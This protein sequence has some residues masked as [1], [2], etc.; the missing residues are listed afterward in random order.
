M[1]RVTINGTVAATTSLDSVILVELREG[2]KVLAS[3]YY[4]PA[5]N[6]NTEA[7]TNFPRL[8]SLTA[9]LTAGV[10]TLNVHAE[11][12]N[13]GS[14]DSVSFTTNI[15]SQTP[16]M[17][18]TFVSQSV[19]ARNGMEI[20]K[21]YPVS[22]TF[23]NTGNVTWQAGGAHPFRLGSQSPQDNSNFS[24]GRVGLPYNIAPGQQYTFD[25]T[26]IPA[27]TLTTNPIFQWQMLSEGERW[28]GDFSLAQPITLIIP[29]PVA[30]FTSPTSNPTVPAGTILTF[31]GTATPGAGASIAK[32]ELLLNDVV[33][34]TGTT[35]VSA[36][37]AL[38]LG[39]H[40]LEL[41]ATDTRGLTGSDYRG[42]L[43]N[44]L[45]PNVRITAP[46]DGATFNLN[47]GSTVSVPITAVATPTAGT[48][49]SSFRLYVDGT[50]RQ[51]VTTGN[52][53]TSVALA[54][55]AHT[56][57]VE[58][59]DILG[60]ISA[61]SSIGVNV[62]ASV[63]TATLTS[64]TSNS[65]LVAQA[66][67]TAN[68]TVNGTAAATGGATITAFDLLDNGTVI[69]SAG[70]TTNF[71]SA[72]NLAVG[73]HVLSLRATSSAGRQGSSGSVT[74]TV[75]A[76]GT[77][78][79]AV[80]LSAAPGNVRVS[81]SQ[82]AAITFTASSTAASGTT[83]RTLELFKGTDAAGSMGTTPVATTTA[84]SATASWAPIINLPAGVHQFKLRSTSSNGLSAESRPVFVNV[85]NSALLGSTTGVRT[86]AG[87]NPELFG[88]TCQPGNAAA[89]TYKVLLDAPTIAAGAITLTSGTAD[90]ASEPDNAAIGNTCSTPGSPHHF[91]VNLSPYIA[92]YA[93]RPLYVAVQ[94]QNQSLGTTLPCADNSCTMPGTMRVALTTPQN[95][96]QIRYPNP[97]FVRMLLSNY[98]GAIDEVAFN[99]NG[100][101]VAAQADG[102]AG[103]YSASVAGLSASTTPYLVYAK[104]RQGN[105]TLLSMPR[106][107]TVVAGVVVALNSPTAGA[108]LTVGTAQGLSASAPDLASSLKFFANGA[109]V[110]TGVK[111]NG[112]WSSSWTPTAAGAF[113]LTAV[114]YDGAGAQVGQSA[115]VN[116]N[117]LIGNGSDATPLPVNVAT[118]HLD[119]AD[120]GTL[121]GELNVGADGA[122]SYRV[123]IEVPPGTAGMQPKLSLSYSSNGPN[124]LVGLGWSLGGLSTLHRCAKTI[125]QDGVV[126]RISVTTSDRLCLNGMRL[127]RSSGAN[128]AADAGAQDAAYWGSAGTQ[129][130][131]EIE[132]FARITSLSKGF[133]VEFKD[134]RIQYFGHD[135]DTG[136]TSSAI[137]AQGRSNESLLWALA[138]TEDRSGNTMTVTY[139]TDMATGEYVPMQIRYGAN[140]SA[141]QQADLAV[142]FSYETRPDAQ[143]QYMGGSRNDL[144][145]RLTNVQTF[146][147]TA[148]DGSAGTRVRNYIVRYTASKNSNRSLVDSIQACAA[149]DNACLPRTSFSWGSG[150]LKLTLKKEWTEYVNG[151]DDAFPLKVV[152]GDFAGDGTTIHLYP[153][154]GAP[155]CP[156]CVGTKI[157]P[158]T[159]Q[160]NGSGYFASVALPSGHKFSEVIAGDLDGD[161]RADMVFIDVTSRNWAY[162][163]AQPGGA[164]GTLNFSECQMGPEPLPARRI[165]QG[166]PDDLPNL[167][168]L[169]NDGKDQ[170]LAFDSANRVKVCTY[171][172]SSMSCALQS[173]SVPA[174]TPVFDVVPIDLSKQGMTDFYS[175]WFQENLNR[176]GVTLCNFYNN[177]LVCKTIATSGGRYV[178]T[179][180]ADLNG[181]GLTDFV[182]TNGFGR[183]VNDRR[184]STICLSKET[185]VDCNSVDGSNMP[186]GQDYLIPG[187]GDFTGNGLS[188]SAGT[189]TSSKGGVVRT[190]CHVADGTS[191]CIP[192]DTSAVPDLTAKY[193]HPPEDSAST[194]FIDSSGIP[195][196][197][198]C[199]IPHSETNRPAQGCV[200]YSAAL[201]ANEDRLIALVNGVGQREEVEY[202]RGDDATVYSR[203]ATVDGSER[204]PVYP[205]LANNPG[206]LVR[207]LRRDNGQGNWLSSSYRYAGAM[208]DALGRGSL[209]FAQVSVT[210]PNAVTT[211]TTFAQAFP[212][213]GMETRLVRSTASCVLEQTSNV[214]AQQA[215]S[216]AGGGHNF[217]VSV[218]RSDATRRDL[219]CS[220]LGT[221]QT[222][223]QYT[224]GW[225]NLNV[226]TV[227]TQNGTETFVTKTASV[228]DTGGGANYLSGLPTSVAVTKTNA[229]N[230]SL[231]RT[232]AYTNNTTSGLRET[233]TIEP[234][235]TAYKLL[236][237]YDRSLNTFGLVNKEVQSW[238]D[239]ACADAGWPSSLDGPCSAAKSRVLTDTTYDRKGRFPVT[240]KNALGHAETRSYDP[241]TGGMTQRLDANGLATGWLLDGFGR[242]T[243]ERAPDG[244]ETRHYL[245]AC[246]GSCPGGATVAQVTERF[247]GNA[248]IATPQVAYVDSA[249]H[250]VR[251][252]DWGFDGRKIVTDQRY[253]SLGRLWET[254]WPRFD[255]ATSYLASRHGYDQLNRI[256]SVTSVDEGGTQRTARTTYAGGKLVQTNAK[257]QVRTEWRDAIGQLRQVDDSNSPI[258]STLFEYDPFGNLSKTTDP[259]KNV[260][261]VTYDLLGRKT[262]LR[263]PDLGWTHYDVNPLGLPW[264][265][266]SPN[267]RGASK[268]YTAYDLLGRMTGRYEPDLESHWVYDS[269]A[270]G[271]GQLARASTRTA[272][273]Q[274]DYSR[275]HTYDSVGRP[276]LTRTVLSDGTYVNQTDYDAWGRPI[277]NT[278]QRNAGPAKVF[279]TR[280]NAFGYLARIERGNLALWQ[281]TA[282]DAARR[283]TTLALGN[284]LAQTRRFYPQTG[285]LQ[286]ASLAT[287]TN[288]ARL[289]EGYTYDPLGNVL[290][291]TQFWDA[292]GFI[293]SFTYDRLNRLATS[294][295]QGEASQAF[296]YDATGN[297]VSKT[298]TGNYTYST[299]GAN[300]V[301]PHAVQ[302]VSSLSGTFQYDANGNLR[303]GGG[304]TVTWTSFDMPLT[305]V[306]GSASATLV[307]GPEHQRVRQDRNDGTRIVYAGAQEVE[308]KNG[309]DTVKTYWPNGI[310][311][312]IDRGT[313]ATEMNWIHADRL[314]SVVALTNESGV[315]REKL[316]YDVWGKRRSASDNVSTP[317]SLDGQTDNRG[318]TGHEMLDQLDLVHMNGRVY[319]P[320]L[321]NFLSGDPIIQDHENGQ[322][323]NRYSYVFNNPTNLTDPTGFLAFDGQ[324]VCNMGRDCSVTSF[325]EASSRTREPDSVEGREGLTGNAS[326][327]PGLGQSNSANTGT[328]AGCRTNV[329]C[330][331]NGN[332]YDQ[333]D[334]LYHRYT[335]NSGICNDGTPGCTVEN[336]AMSVKKNAAPGSDGVTPLKD[337][338][339]TAIVFMGIGGGHVTHIVDDKNKRVLNITD[340]DHVFYNGLVIRSVVKDAGTVYVSSFGEGVNKPNLGWLPDALSKIG[341]IITAYPGFKLL[342][343]KIQRDILNQSP[344]GQQI[345]QQQQIRRLERGYHGM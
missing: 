305:I 251:K 36:T 23:K 299:Q 238:L 223:N 284:G 193:G 255:V 166:N 31:A 41:R 239:P 167:V 64:P 209:G 6:P 30:R 148:A 111:A 140:T 18:A 85:T 315:I 336:V 184:G 108:V 250:V 290:E 54:A 187:A 88:W 122:A 199:T 116:V 221:V 331:G 110:A 92:Q 217:F 137:P 9:N 196:F 26:V 141:N 215:F 163:L 16:I 275:T 243:S 79:T 131:T 244:N 47:S 155:Q 311:V 83:I 247:N 253:D 220:A 342:D 40:Q 37:R 337:G 218:G 318:F 211:E 181:D 90:V 10:H 309:V 276:S 321:G 183:G 332:G 62:T 302:T 8:F 320:Q 270:F 135:P 46:A 212:F 237:R 313:A 252:L 3:A 89:L 117:V 186:I 175:V 236:T 246:A 39:I 343:G 277:R 230:V 266:T 257:L 208:R 73:T 177:A 129:Y 146:I 292:G 48:V 72:V 147:N 338:D 229:A 109:L 136:D 101:W 127:F 7:P 234:S 33:I 219:D 197:K 11:T 340:S 52:I 225:G 319:N 263:D 282:Q 289:R 288:L 121:S 67:G 326:Q 170:L 316:A 57:A 159:G 329:D 162:C 105:I 35:S 128:S 87:G 133:K 285:R 160:F 66:N 68:L 94:T 13:S 301:R 308:T 233:E 115:V 43:I 99:V 120:A 45:P 207:Q 161:G 303:S 231:T 126:G 151:D 157:Y 2:N 260:I 171:A 158:Y 287:A 27:L 63:T 119:A 65:T 76:G 269:A 198:Y 248:R 317:D 256:L 77:G 283:P 254:D 12:Y 300:S 168:S 49:L 240:V 91:V 222:V 80:A 123:D 132:G 286:D 327:R 278:Y 339:K 70:A 19:P 75:L 304:R 291:R 191:R 100:Q 281:V 310:G 345:L 280:Y 188:Y 241:S 107:F 14:G 125:A 169:R 179:S 216:L 113:A 55:G 294:Q 58:A 112:T 29:G 56:L 258:G 50:L 95:G 200:A 297:I 144:R 22:V 298:G 106:Q 97:V 325:S 15:A 176:S 235:N 61:R 224:D 124:G 69:R 228:F 82:T 150:S 138:R 314:G 84:S 195:A 279:G 213:I 307:Y 154:L 214:L 295:V 267:Q 32:I 145:R 25:F 98:S 173:Y 42:V 74:V 272:S 245:K 189:I 328:P 4:D 78:P 81:G 192:I 274:N 322:N 268:T 341:N 118:P 139:S 5:I 273:A 102:A 24:I 172:S 174:D 227:T 333:K 38:P 262:D 296:G 59:T 86:N 180:P 44:P 142:R 264:A 306:K 182:F 71:S 149:S 21:S 130:R 204:K 104:A 226:Q 96:D 34:A 271:V 202:S 201:P 53:N 178:T 210:D 242:V 293:E 312:E 1:S 344:Q 203:L 259:S 114:A 134:G 232:V 153:M 323:Y 330:G 324:S 335:I 190:L 17:G 28:F 165:H 261:V 185:D 93:G 152:S 205:Q 51:T 164:N 20:G 249:G 206:V 60:S 194:F 156:Q 103:A 143:I 265:Q 334:A